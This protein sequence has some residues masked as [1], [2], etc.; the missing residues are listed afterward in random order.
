METPVQVNI[1]KDIGAMRAG[2]VKAALGYISDAGILRRALY[3][4]CR[5]KNRQVV[6][7]LLRIRLRRLGR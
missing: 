4:E 2:E 3:G 6:K 5:G 7:S 1:E